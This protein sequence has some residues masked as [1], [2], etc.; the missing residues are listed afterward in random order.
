MRIEHKGYVAHQSDY[1]NHVMITE[2]GRMVFHASCTSKMSEQE[3]ENLVDDF[4][5]LLEEL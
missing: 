2:N 5:K 3:L 1:N 4:I